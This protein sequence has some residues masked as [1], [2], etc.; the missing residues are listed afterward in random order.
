MT[1]TETKIKKPKKPTRKQ[2]KKYC[3]DWMFFNLETKKQKRIVTNALYELHCEVIDDYFNWLDDTKKV[4]TM[5]DWADDSG[6]VMETDEP[7][8]PCTYREWVREYNGR[9]TATYCSGMG[10]Q[11]DTISDDVHDMVVSTINAMCKQLTDGDYDAFVDLIGFGD[12]PVVHL[13]H[14]LID[15]LDQDLVFD[16]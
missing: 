14:E 6:E 4:L 1:K 12:D 3:S 9:W 10:K 15:G 7:N 5:P 8:Q 11:H 2:I 13:Y 16:Y